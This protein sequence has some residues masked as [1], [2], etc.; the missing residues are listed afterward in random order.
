MTF[1]IT[2]LN[3]PTTKLTKI[4]LLYPDTLLPVDSSFFNTCIYILCQREYTTE[5]QHQRFSDGLDRNWFR[6]SMVWHFYRG[7]H[8]S[9]SLKYKKVSNKDLKVGRAQRALSTHLTIRQRAIHHRQL[10]QHQ[11]SF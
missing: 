3:I 9:Q 5:K 2:F 7:K 4:L 1:C 11:L 6:V 10:R 8:C